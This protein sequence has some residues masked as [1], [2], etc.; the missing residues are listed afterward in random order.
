MKRKPITVVYRGHETSGVERR[1]TMKWKKARKKP[2]VIEF[3]EVEPNS[4]IDVKGIYVEAEKI[5]T[6]EGALYGFPTKDLMIRG[7]KG[8][9]YPI[10]K[11]IFDATYE[12]IE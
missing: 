6:R 10:G 5:V 11:E 12:V 9:L 4:E 2:I 3:R 7:I 8:E 1:N